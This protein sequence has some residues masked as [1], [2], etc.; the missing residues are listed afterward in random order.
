MVSSFPVP[1]LKQMAHMAWEF[2]R[3]NHTKDKFAEEFR[4]TMVKILV[5][6]NVQG[7]IPDPDKPQP[8]LPKIRGSGGKVA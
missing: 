7:F 5:T 3:A 6:H 1:K 4:K 8:I 2:A